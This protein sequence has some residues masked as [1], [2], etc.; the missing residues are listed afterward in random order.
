[1]AVSI[2]FI[3]IIS[4]VQLILFLRKD[5]IYLSGVTEVGLSCYLVLLI[6]K[7][8]NLT[9]AIPW[10]DPFT[11]SMMTSNGNIFHVIGPLCGECTGHQWIPS[12]AELWCFLWSSPWINGWVNNREAGDLRH[13][14]AHYDIIVMLSFS[15]IAYWYGPGS[16]NPS[17]W[18][19]RIHVS[20]TGLILVCIQPMGDSGTL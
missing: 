12:D 20:Y 4:W 2:I 11:L 14:L 13:H 19:T 1:M 7:T 5:K 10:P 15:T 8:E 9:A 6:E 16:W 17:S 18:K 3:W